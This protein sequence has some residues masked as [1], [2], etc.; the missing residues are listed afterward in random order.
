MLRKYETLLALLVCVVVV[1]ASLFQ[2]YAF[3]G[4]K[5][6]GYIS[7]LVHGY[8]P[9]YYYYLSLMQQGAEG[10]IL[11]TSRYTSEYFAPQFV[12]T[13]FVLAGFLGSG[14][15]RLWMPHVY[16]L[17]R[18]T[19]G[20]LVLW[21]GYRLAGQLFSSVYVRLGAFALMIVGAPFW[22]KQGAIFVTSGSFWAEFDP[23]VR[24]V[25]LPHHMAAIVLLMWAFYL[26]QTAKTFRNYVLSGVLGALGAWCNPA[27]LFF[28]VGGIGIY[29]AASIIQRMQLKMIMQTFF[30]LLFPS[31]VVIVAFQLLQNSV[32]PWTAFRDW[33]A[34]MRYEL[35]GV[36]FLNVLGV[37]GYIALLGIVFCL[38][39]KNSLWYL[40]IGWFVVPIVVLT[41]PSNLLPLSNARFFQGFSHIPAALLAAVAIS[42]IV[43][44]LWKVGVSVNVSLIIFGSILSIN[45]IPSY[46]ASYQQQMA[47]VEQDR[48]NIVQ[49]MSPEVFA[50]M[51]A[52]THLGNH[53]DVVV[54]PGWLSTMIPGITD[55]RTITGHPTFTYDGNTKGA[56]LAAIEH[57]T[58]ISIVND[59]ATIEHVRFIWWEKL[60]NGE[61]LYASIAQKVYENERYALYQLY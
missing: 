56:H 7:P 2:T 33:E 14:V 58:D 43:R 54:A 53:D 40:V 11:V 59:V 29:G 51:E 42:R 4:A 31:L 16:L 1:F 48:W 13:F 46:I 41:V 44:I 55:K 24:F 20:I 25:Y 9:D 32:F 26:I 30:V 47:S 37:V 15:L 60:Q 6:A 8:Q 10:K 18:V 3:E 50:T 19:F 38:G 23:V 39:Q 12:N 57:P 34:G 49:Y 17:L 28:Y 45:A 21:G 27:V 36:G 35:N 52:L 5:P 61:P 22:A